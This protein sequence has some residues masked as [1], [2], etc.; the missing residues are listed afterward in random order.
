MSS[1][2]GIS[3]NR[4]SARSGLRLFTLAG[5]ALSAAL[6]LVAVGTSPV[7]ADML[8]K[9][10]DGRTISVPVS[11]GEIDSVTY[12][13]PPKAAKPATAQPASRAAAQIREDAESLRRARD[14]ETRAINAATAAAAAAETARKAADEAK[15]QADA[16]RAA[17][18]A[19]EKLTRTAPS[20]SAPSASSAG[21]APARPGVS[22]PPA[23][24]TKRPAAA[25]RVIK[26]GPG[27]KYTRPSE[28][29]K[30][31]R[32]GDVIE[33][34]AGRYAGDVA[35]WKAHNLTIRGVDGGGAI[36][37]PHLDAQGKSA[38]R[39]AT[40]VIVGN[41]YLIENIEFSNS[42][43]SDRNGAGI[44]LEGRN[45][46]V[47][48]SYFHHNQMGILTGHNPDS[49]V[50]IEDSE[51][52]ANTV[53]Y[54]K[55]GSLGHNIYIGRVRSFTLR[56]S[57]SHGAV[58]GHNVKT[59]ARENRLL[60][61]RLEDGK[62]GAASYIVDVAEGGSTW[63][64][65]NVIEQGPDGDNWAIVSFGSEKRGDGD[66]LALV[67]NTMINN[68]SSGV[69]VQTHGPVRPVLMNNILA[70]RGTP[71]KGTGT[72]Q[73]NL[74]AKSVSAG[75][76]GSLIGRGKTTAGTGPLAGNLI[77]DIAG[78]A[79]PKAFDFRLTKE[80]PARDKGTEPGLV[81]GWPSRPASQY[82]HPVKTADRPRQGK[83][84][85]GAY[86]LAP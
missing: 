70:G 78:F 24:A 64:V 46:T 19:A 21:A 50:M 60:Y 82:I 37:R 32:N 75:L 13:A 57:Y 3:A 25:P 80:S 40:W 30:A 12:G 48:N 38:Q 26:V 55:T 86:E 18:A 8:I 22:L 53:D 27:E 71:L 6:G 39:K 15:R 35:V 62:D 2:L 17:R 14:A 63:L 45:L 58:T 72:L 84:D 69:F 33:I 5:L 42:R 68:R 11:P 66:R 81:N 29:A 34:A 76:L 83:I 59:R 65:G 61:N 54:K 49:D 1:H 85:I 77:A 4:R 52:Y 74:I 16:A 41:D 20:A 9:L 7:S 23:P 47:R 10:K 56:G 79:D 31:A 44:R 43:V 28:A 51:F 73:S 36:K 67:N